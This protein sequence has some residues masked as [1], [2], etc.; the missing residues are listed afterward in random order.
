MNPYFLPNNTETYLIQLVQKYH[1]E[2]FA[3]IRMSTTMLDKSIIDASKEFRS[4]LYD[5]NLINFAAISQGSKMIQNISFL[6]EYEILSIKTSFYRP[7]TKSGDPRFWIYNLRKFV[8]VGDLIY[9]TVYN[10]NLIAIPVVDHNHFEN[11]LV[12]VFGINTDESILIE[13]KDKI[14]ILAKKGWIPSVSP[15]KI[16]D[17]DIGETLER[18]LG[19]NINNLKTPDFKGEIEIKG[20]TLGSGTKDSLFSMVPNWQLSF[21]KG[22]NEMALN[23]GYPDREYEGYKSLFVTVGHTPNKQGLY[24]EVDEDNE[25]IIQNCI[26]PTGVVVVCVWEFSEIKNRLYSKHP[27]TMWIVAE[28]KKINS[29]IHFRYIEVQYTKDPIFT[30][31]LYLVQQGYITFDWRRRARLTATEILKASKMDYGHGFRID[32]RYRHLLFGETT[33]IELY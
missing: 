14:S 30:Q 17:K 20:K 7:N 18:E 22:A 2:E 5:S 23:Y 19:V 10:S 1:R 15:N 27:K 9:F 28:A 12:D 16:N 13:L 3:L 25:I 8:E 32:P 31:F 21:V 11:N 26:T 6:S 29:I 33:S 4:I 24:L